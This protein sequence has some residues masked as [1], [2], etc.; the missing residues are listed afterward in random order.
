LVG[1]AVGFGGG[2]ALE[3]FCFV[4]LVGFVFF[5]VYLFNG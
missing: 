5:K 2:H 3:F 4:C 1:G